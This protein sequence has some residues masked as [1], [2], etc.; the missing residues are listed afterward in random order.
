MKYHIVMIVKEKETGFFSLLEDIAE[1]NGGFILTDS[2][3]NAGI[4][5]S[6]LSYYEK[7]GYLER[8]TKGQY[9]FPSEIS[10][11]MYS[12]SQRSKNLIFSHESALFLHNM[13]SR[14]PFYHSITVP[15]DK[16]LSDRLKKECKVY[17]VKTELFSLGLMYSKT[18][19]GNLVPCYDAERTICDIIR[20]RNR[21][22][23]E[24]FYDGI[25][26]YMTGRET[27][28]GKLGSYA[29]QFHILKKV[30]DILGVL[31]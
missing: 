9:I 6:L 16:R 27:D 19:H 23:E 30:R 18:P 13:S 5:R 10:D 29:E 15:S 14:T 28:I 17:Y 12:I 1:K 24:T 8:I 3:V 4:S 31:L 7:Q 11:E 26:Q 21:I 22:D 20:S 25:K 2:A